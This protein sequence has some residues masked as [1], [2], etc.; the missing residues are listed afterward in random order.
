MLRLVRFV[1][2][3]RRRQEGTPIRVCADG[4]LADGEI[5]RVEGLSAIICNVGGRLHALGLVCP[6]A[7]ARLST[8]KIV[9]DCVECPL[10]G[11]R[12]A[13]ED[14]AVRRG[15]AAHGLPA[16]DVVIR[17]GAVYVYRRPRRPGRTGRPGRHGRHGNARGAYR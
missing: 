1:R 7:G 6:H 16:Y 13:I 11:A 12:F 2:R 14:G 15:P 5:R 3:R 17:E 8:G 9:G 10:H 4:E